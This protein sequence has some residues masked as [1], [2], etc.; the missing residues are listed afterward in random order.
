MQWLTLPDA[1][2]TFGQMLFDRELT[3]KFLRAAMP[4]GRVPTMR[5]EVL[6]DDGR[7]IQTVKT[8]SVIH[9]VVKLWGDAAIPNAPPRTKVVLRY[10]FDPR[11]GTARW[12]GSLE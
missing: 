8:D 10:R 12:Y 7:G 9:P 3:E 1:R 2:S 6:F 11:A 5:G 4:R